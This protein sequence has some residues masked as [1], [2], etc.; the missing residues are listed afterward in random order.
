MGGQQVG[1]TDAKIKGLK[2]PASGQ[3]EYPDKQVAGLRVRIGSTGAKTFIFRKRIGSRVS[4]MTL[5]RY[6]E[7]RFTLADARKKARGLLSDIESGGDP[8]MT[9]ETPRKG[10]KGANTIRKLWPDYKAAKATRRSIGE[11]E[12]IFDRYILPEIGDR[13]ADAV[14]RADVTRLIDD[15]AKTAPVMARGVHAQLSAFYTW[16]MPR[17]DRLPANPCRDAGR[18][19]APKPRERVLS[20]EELK[21]LWKVADKEPKPWGPAIKLLILTGQRRDEVIKAEHSEFDLKAKLWTIPGAR[22]KNG[23]V[24]LVPLSAPAVAVLKGIDTVEGT[25]KLFPARGN[26]EAATSGYSKAWGK[27]FAQVENELGEIERFTIHDLRRTMAT[28][29]Q[30]LGIAMPVTEAVLNH[31]SGSRAGI[32]GV[33]QRHDFQAEKRHALDAWAAE[34]DRIAK[35]KRRGNVVAIRG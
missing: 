2:S 1:L 12:R 32:V 11:I 29:L 34:I 14:T 6:H 5:G 21:A 10:G 4:N 25:D 27:I 23:K 20:D 17:L 7:S 31:I 8:T 33:Y 13:L 3:V 22:A 18:P 35:G 26:S 16:A 9:L 24:H 15:I 30:R 19:P 28:G